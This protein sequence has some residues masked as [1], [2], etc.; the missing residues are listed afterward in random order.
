MHHVFFSPLFSNVSRKEIMLKRTSKQLLTK[1]SA[2]KIGS[3]SI[4][5]LSIKETKLR[6]EALKVELENRKLKGKKD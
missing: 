5:N 2:Y 4:R 3:N 6:A 1:F